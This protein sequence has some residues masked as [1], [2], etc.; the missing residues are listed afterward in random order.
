MLLWMAAFMLGT[1]LVSFYSF[2]V[3][4]E[5]DHDFDQTQCSWFEA[6]NKFC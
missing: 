2:N 5:P 6:C 3:V 4:A 1:P